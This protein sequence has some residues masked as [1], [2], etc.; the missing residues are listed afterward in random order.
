MKTYKFE[1]G[2]TD[3]KITNLYKTMLAQKEAAKAYKKADNDLHEKTK[4]TIE[5]S[6]LK[7]C[8]NSQTIINTIEKI[9]LLIF[10]VFKNLK[11]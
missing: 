9:L 4:V 3:E 10:I 7:P 5:N 8:N 2:S 6:S 11:T 1:E